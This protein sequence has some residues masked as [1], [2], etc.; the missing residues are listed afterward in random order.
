MTWIEVDECKV[1][2]VDGDLHKTARSICYCIRHHTSAVMRSKWFMSCQCTFCIS[3]IQVRITTG[4]WMIL[5]RIEWGT[6]SCLNEIK[7]RLVAFGEDYKLIRLSRVLFSNGLLVN[8]MQWQMEFPVWPQDQELFIPFQ[9]VTM[10]Q[11]R[12]C[13]ACKGR[14]GRK[15]QVMRIAIYTATQ[16]SR[17]VV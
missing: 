8:T 15:L 12:K 14:L 2:V 17:S 10:N 3:L 5:W 1:N 9:E 7:P 16:V 6:F 4:L 13:F 11:T